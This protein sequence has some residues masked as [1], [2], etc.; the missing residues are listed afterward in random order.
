M[1]FV[2]SLSTLLILMIGSLAHAQ[3]VTRRATI[4]RFEYSTRF[5][6]SDGLP[7]NKIAAFKEYSFYE[8]P[9]A[10]RRA[11][12]DSDPLNLGETVFEVT[13]RVD[14]LDDERALYVHRLEARARATCISK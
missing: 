6:C 1:K 7:G 3:V 13:C 11:C 10:A 12:A 9:Q 8:M 14:R 5:N 4:E 2:F